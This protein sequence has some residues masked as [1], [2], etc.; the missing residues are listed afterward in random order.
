MSNPD[1]VD[2]DWVELRE[3]L[4]Y[5]EHQRWADWQEY[6]FNL[7]KPQDS[8][9]GVGKPINLVIPSELVERWGR[10]INTPYSELSEKEKDSDREQ[11]D[12]YLPLIQA[13][14]KE[15]YKRLALELIGKHESGYRDG[16]GKRQSI[17]T[18]R[19]NLRKE[20]DARLRKQLYN[21]KGE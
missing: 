2:T 6:Q 19:N 12:R 4:A 5:I 17:Q 1:I 10:Q 13:K 14:F 7:C 21:M 8:G 20:Q 11:V 15:N 3:K 9:R 16:T 18:A